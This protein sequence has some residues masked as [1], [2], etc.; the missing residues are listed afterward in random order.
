MLLDRGLLERDGSGYRI[1]GPVETLEVPETL[2]ALIASR[3]DGLP[4][5]EHHVLQDAAVLGKTF[6]RR[7]LAAL[8]GLNEDAVEPLIA[9][10]LRK[11]ILYLE[12]DPRSAERGHYGFLQALVQRVAYETLGR[13]ER[14]SRHLAAAGYLAH[15]SGIGPVRDRRGHRGSL[16][17]CVQGRREHTRCGG[18]EGIGEG[19][20]RT[21]S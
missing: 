2:H 20:V 18:D 11:E 17:R 21:R 1:T 4:E 9:A 3:L 10:L 7:G 6:T 19:L 8:S 16:R 5:E 13:R 15:D 14:R 12:A